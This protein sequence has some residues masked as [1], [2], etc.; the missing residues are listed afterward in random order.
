MALVGNSKD[1]IGDIKVSYLTVSE[2]VSENG[3]S[4]VL[5]DGTALPGGS[6]YGTLTSQTNKPDFRGEFLRGSD[7]GRGADS[8]RGFRS[9]QAENTSASDLSV[10]GSATSSGGHHHLE[11]VWSL[12]STGNYGADSTGVGHNNSITG[13]GNCNHTKTSS[14][15]DHAHPISAVVS[16]SSETRPR[17]VAVNYF[18]KI[19]Y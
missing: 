13:S 8:G 11:G 9:S 15:G 14:V 2:F 18:I 1:S 4:W 3:N 10:S 5:C 7:Q 6:R 19:N 12:N 16:G 17:N